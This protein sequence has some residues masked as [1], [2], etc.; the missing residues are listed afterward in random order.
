[1]GSSQS[2]RRSKR[3]LV[4]VAVESALEMVGDI[5]KPWELVTNTSLS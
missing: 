5:D 4:E 1:M 2:E 3:V